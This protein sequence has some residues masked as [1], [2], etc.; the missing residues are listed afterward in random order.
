MPRS[1]RNEAPGQHARRLAESEALDHARHTNNGVAER[2]TPYI[3]LYVL[4]VMTNLPHS[5]ACEPV[6]K[7]GFNREN[8]F[9]MD[10]AVRGRV[11]IGIARV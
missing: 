3:S 6:G 4:S 9:V 8:V 1:I 2:A 5:S 11:R 7:I 10:N